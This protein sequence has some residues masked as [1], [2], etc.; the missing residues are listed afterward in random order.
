[1]TSV[2]NESATLGAMSALMTRFAGRDGTWATA[3]PR[4]SFIRFS[5][6]HQPRPSHYLPCFCLITQG[7]KPIAPTKMERQSAKPQTTGMSQQ[8]SAPWAK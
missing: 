1:M 5:T 7:S 4:L 8:R 6:P 3:I 2:P